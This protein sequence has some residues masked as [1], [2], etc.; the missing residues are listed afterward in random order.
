MQS[1]NGAREG[2]GALLPA[3]DLPRALS[4]GDDLGPDHRKRFF[5]TAAASATS[6]CLDAL[7]ESLASLLFSARRRAAWSGP[8]ISNM[9]GW[10]LGIIPGTGRHSLWGLVQHPRESGAL[11]L[12]IDFEPQLSAAGH[13]RM[14]DYHRQNIDMSAERLLLSRIAGQDRDLEAITSDPTSFRAALPGDPIRRIAL[15]PIEMAAHAPAPGLPKM[16]ARPG[17]WG[18]DVRCANF[19][20]ALPARTADRRVLRSLSLIDHAPTSRLDRA[21]G[22]G[23]PRSAPQCEIALVRAPLQ[24]V[25]ALSILSDFLPRLGADQDVRRRAARLGLCQWRHRGRGEEAAAVEYGIGAALRADGF[26]TSGLV[27]Q[28][29][30]MA[31]E[32]AA[33]DLKQRL[34]D[35]FFLRARAQNAGGVITVDGCESFLTTESGTSDWEGLAFH[36]LGK[37]YRITFIGDEKDDGFVEAIRIELRQGVAPPRHLATFLLDEGS[38]PPGAGPDGLMSRMTDWELKH[39]NSAMNAIDEAYYLLASERE[40]VLI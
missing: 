24:A 29:H 13:E 31:I 30:R 32:C 28:I 16:I 34:Y 14:R 37:E 25:E 27:E 12:T 26:M 9:A 39:F 18:N 38:T 3:P 6:F 19:S 2:H 11:L 4:D 15:V 35:I 17:T 7:S 23:E 36:Q 40:P 1:S 33:D 20:Q 5:A 21:P 8:G 22:S 10:K